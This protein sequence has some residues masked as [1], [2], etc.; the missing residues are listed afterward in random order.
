MELCRRTCDVSTTEKYWVLKS[1]VLTEEGLA[2]LCGLGLGG[3]IKIEP[4]TVAEV[5]K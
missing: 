2:V 3:G 1:W 4:V 5:L